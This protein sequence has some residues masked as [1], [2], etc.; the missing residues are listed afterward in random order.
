MT[1]AAEALRSL[2]SLAETAGSTRAALERWPSAAQAPAIA[3]VGRRARIGAPPDDVTEPLESWPDG[4]V[5]GRAIAAHA[6][7]GG[8]LARTLLALADAIEGRERMAHEARMAGS[9]SKLSTRLL[10]ALAATCALLL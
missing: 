6:T 9:A 10:G 3:K 7:H 4:R 8:S 5:I 1:T 2:A